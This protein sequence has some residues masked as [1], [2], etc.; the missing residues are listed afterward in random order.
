MANSFQYWDNGFPVVT[1]DGETTISMQYWDS[2]FP[3]GYLGDTGVVYT[4]KTRND[5]ARSSIKTINGLPIG[6]LKL[7]NDLF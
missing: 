7:R 6:S 1:E 2:G 3:F 5:L 4:L